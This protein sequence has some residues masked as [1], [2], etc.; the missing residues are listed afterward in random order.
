MLSISLTNS[1]LVDFG[2][3]LSGDGRQKGD[4]EG[5]HVCYMTYYYLSIEEQTCDK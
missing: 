3:Y 4:T 2:S 1:H 5:T